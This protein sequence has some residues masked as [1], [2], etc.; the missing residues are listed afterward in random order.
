MSESGSETPIETTGRGQG[1]PTSTCE[2]RRAAERD[3]VSYF[4][5]L[6]FGDQKIFHVDLVD[7]SAI[8]A[9]MIAPPDCDPPEE[10][11][12]KIPETGACFLSEIAWRNGS[13]FGVRFKSPIAG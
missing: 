13:T 10:V 7:L 12:L 9:R 11:V 2:T 1:S 5:I 4:G 8:G 3:A 6:S